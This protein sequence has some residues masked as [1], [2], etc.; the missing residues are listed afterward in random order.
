[1]YLLLICS[2]SALFIFTAGL[3]STSSSFSHTFFSSY[4]FC[5]FWVGCFLSWFNNLLS[6]FSFYCSWLMFF[7]FCWRHCLLFIIFLERIPFSIRLRSSSTFFIFSI[8]VI[9]HVILY[10]TKKYLVIYKNILF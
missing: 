10:R 4:F 5:F 8:F 2:S 6:H 1:M 3:S 7:Y 9:S